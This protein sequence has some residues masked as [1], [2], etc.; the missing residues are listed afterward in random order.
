MGSLPQKTKIWH[1]NA[2]SRRSGKHLLL[3]LRK[4]AKS[5][6]LQRN[7]ERKRG[8]RKKRLTRSIAKKPVERRKNPSPNQNQN[9][10]QLEEQNLE[11][12]EGRLQEKS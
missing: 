10:D 3:F 2:V 11:K 5:Y 8:A 6:V 7:V 4:I 9:I 12:L 1:N